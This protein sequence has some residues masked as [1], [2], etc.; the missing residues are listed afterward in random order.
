VRGV[1]LPIVHAFAYAFLNRAASGCNKVF[2]TNVFDIRTNCLCRGGTSYNI[3]TL[4]YA[5]TPG[6]DALKYQVINWLCV[7]LLIYVHSYTVYRR[8]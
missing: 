5:N 8:D 2:R 7:E 3:V 1:V 6:G 4:D